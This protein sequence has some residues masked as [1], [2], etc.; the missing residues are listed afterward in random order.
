MRYVV[1]CIIKAAITYHDNKAK[2]VDFLLKAN[3]PEANF[4][5]HP[6]DLFLEDFGDLDL[7]LKDL[8]DLDFA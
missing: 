4:M 1:I 6:L 2:F 7:F 3:N 5:H 8:V